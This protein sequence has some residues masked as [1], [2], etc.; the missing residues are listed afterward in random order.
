[1]SESRE[2]Q[3]AAWRRSF[4]NAGESQVRLML[5]SGAY[6]VGMRSVVMQWLT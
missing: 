1:M 2:Q 5:S 6:P 4:E 3:E